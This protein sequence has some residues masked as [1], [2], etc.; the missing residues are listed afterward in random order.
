MHK[1]LLISLAVLSLSTALV[2]DPT[3][4]V[5]VKIGAITWVAGL[6]NAEKMA[7]L[8]HRPILHFQLFGNLDEKYCCTNARTLRA[9]VLSQADVQSYLASNFVTSWEMARPVPKVS[10]DFGDGKKV[11][12][13]VKGN[14][15]LYLC[16]PDGRVVDAW[17]GVYTK[18]DLLAGIKGTIADLK[19]AGVDVGNPGLGAEK[20]I[21]EWQ[22]RAGSGATPTG[23]SSIAL[24][25]TK[26]VVEGPVMKILGAKAFADA[27][28][29]PKA[30]API[31]ASTQP[32]MIP[33]S[34]G[35]SKGQLAKL[36][37]R[38]T[39][40][41]YDSSGYAIAADD[42]VKS[43]STRLPD[44]DDPVELGRRAIIEDSFRNKRFV[45]PAVHMWLGSLSKLPTPGESKSL[46][47]SKILRV[48]IDDPYLGLGVFSIPGTPDP[49]SK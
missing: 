13:T 3:K 48:P 35:F 25:V 40:R 44:T 17:P 41:F 34:E 15:V 24:T 12:R 43:V 2:A 4:A 19:Q 5:D 29:Q 21:L 6:E 9:T 11:E 38:Y 18:E 16:L 37:T 7:A 45:R 14:A 32:V 33:G 23:D 27:T 26:S 8:Q 46:V 36:F 31:Q 28:A 30:V 42:V 39:D 22:Q 1:P 49:G 20:G 47:F 10:I